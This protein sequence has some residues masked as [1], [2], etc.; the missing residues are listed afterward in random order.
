MLRQVENIYDKG[1]QLFV[2]CSNFFAAYS[3]TSKTS[4]A[5][6]A[7]AKILGDLSKLSDMDEPEL[8]MFKVLRDSYVRIIEK[9]LIKPDMDLEEL[10]N[11]VCEHQAMEL[12]NASFKT[13][14]TKCN[15]PAK[16]KEDEVLPAA[17]KDKSKKETKKSGGKTRKTFLMKRTRWDAGVAELNIAGPIARLTSQAWCVTCVA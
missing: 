5:Y 8:V 9:V 14:T 11:L 7:R 13:K 10:T 3:G 12:I 4:S 15:K 16:L 2:K 1:N 6:I 17:E